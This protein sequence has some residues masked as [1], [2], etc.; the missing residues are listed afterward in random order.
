MTEATQAATPAAPTSFAEESSELSAVD[1]F[2]QI[3][4]TTHELN[5]PDDAPPED[6][7]DGPARTESGEEPDATV[8]DGEPSGEDAGNEDAAGEDLPPIDPPRSWTKEERKAFEALPRELQQSIAERERVRHADIDRRLNEVATKSKAAE[9]RETAAEQARKQFEDAL[10]VLQSTIQSMINQEFADIKSWDDVQKMA[11]E[12]PVRNSRWLALREQ[13]RDVAAQVEIAQTR[14]QKEAAAK[15]AKFYEEQSKLFIEKA[16]EW[17]DPKK[18]T[19]LR[20]KAF[21]TLH[22]LGFDEAEINDAWNTGGSIPVHDH[23]FQLLVWKAQRFDA[24]SKTVKTPQAPKAV[25]QVQRPGPATTAKDQRSEHLKNLETRLSR[26][27]TSRSAG[28][29]AGLALM[30]AE[31]GSR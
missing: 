17:A 31:R 12:D 7:V 26:A 9:A 8:P 28:L 11:S 19:E 14:Q 29:K 3:N 10:P 27:G 1:A 22:D 13:A 16:P 18:A 5:G 21:G 2:R 25:P 15:S 30:R 20:A 23:R 6:G 24:A 4:K